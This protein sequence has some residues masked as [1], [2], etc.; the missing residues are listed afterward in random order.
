MPGGGVARHASA[1][2][3][4]AACLALPPL[5]V[6]A[7]G[8]TLLV[9]ASASG[10]TTLAASFTPPLVASVTAS[11]SAGGLTLSTGQFPSFEWPTAT[12]PAPPY[13]L[14]TGTQ[15]RM[16]LVAIDAGASVKIG[17]T[18]LDAPGESAALG[19][20]VPGEHVHPEWQLTLPTGTL[21]SRAVQFVFT[22]TGYT[23]SPVYSVTITNAEADTPTPTES[24][25]QPPATP[26]PT[27]PVA[28]TPS[29]TS[30]PPPSA[31]P[32][33]AVFACPATPAAGPCHGA[34]HAGLV[35]ADSGTPARRRLMATWTRADGTDVAALGDPLADTAYALCVYDH[36]AGIPQLI[37]SALVPANGQCGARPCW[38]R[39]RSGRLRYRDR[40]RARDGVAVVSLRPGASGRGALGVKAI[41]PIL[42]SLPLGQDPAVVVQL[43]NALGSC[44]E[45]SFGPPAKQNDGGHFTDTTD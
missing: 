40:D 6:W 10:G 34:A 41:P 14:P 15:V 7:H 19:G 20:T 22:A 5:P 28:D 32:T 30:S 13:P 1:L 42:P 33:A 11:F 27:A 3:W 24:A 26:T 17:A 36:S 2:L 37:W 23:G 18:T 44:W 29:P 35:I 9:G 21:A 16:Q 12:S 25:T 4:V 31:T 43:R 39:A 38:Q 8:E 45:S